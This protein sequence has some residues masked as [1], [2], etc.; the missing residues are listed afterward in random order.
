M[1]FK[2]P[3]SQIMQCEILT[4]GDEILIGQI[5]NTNAVWMSKQLNSIGISVRYMTT[6]GDI[7]QEI[8]NAL[9]AAL[10]RVDL[11]LIT[12]GLGPTSDDITKPALC[13]FFNCGLRKEEEVV[14]FIKESFNKRGIP[15]LPVHEQQAF[16]PEKSEILFNHFGTAPGMWFNHNGRIVAVMPGVPFEMKGI[17]SKYVL[18]RLKSNFQLPAIV[19]KTV[20]IIGIP[21][22]SLSEMLA[23]AEAKLPQH[24]KLAYLPNFGMVRLRLTAK[25][26]DESALYKETEAHMQFILSLIEPKFVAAESDLKP[27]EIIGVLLKKNQATLGIAESCTGG[28][29]SH[30]I[31]SIAGS[32]AYFNGAI[33]SYSNEVKMSTLGVSKET[34]D[35]YGAVSE[36]CAMEM[37]V[38]ARRVLNSDYALSTTGI[39]GPDGGSPDKPVGTVWMAIAGPNGVFAK[40]ILSNGERINI[41]ERSALMVIDMLRRE[42]Q[43]Q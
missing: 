14:T 34:L 22:S 5:V 7:K 30:L 12:G 43:E 37:A 23:P 26:A 19:H 39:A 2:A 31:T 21:E 24:I 35:N 15:F 1:R 6:V 42:L 9:D 16:I 17:M 32:S 27:E 29:V 3:F 25:G 41:I 10:S 18:P 11:V 13:E 40:K 28:Y 8:L 36:Q 20:V 38:G 4:I 33:V